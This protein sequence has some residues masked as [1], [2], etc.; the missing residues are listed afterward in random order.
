[1]STVT[2]FRA[3]E[4]PVPPHLQP[5]VQ[6]PVGETELIYLS[7]QL[8]NQYSRRVLVVWFGAT[9]HGGVAVPSFYNVIR[10]SKKSFCVAPN[11]NLVSDFRQIFTRPI[12]RL[13]R[14]PIFWLEGVPIIGEIGTV[15]KNSM[16][17]Q[18][19]DEIQY[20]VVRKLVQR[21]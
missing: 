17:V 12:K 2:K 1:M 10:K 19:S 4:T 11:S 20:S 7:H 21:L 5:P 16:Q 8:R 3:R 18:L 13:D 9:E 15:E 6:L 14:F